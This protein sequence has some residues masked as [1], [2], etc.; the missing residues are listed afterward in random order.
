MYLKNTTQRE[1]HLRSF[2]VYAFKLPPGISV[3]WD[4]AGEQLLKIHKVESPGGKDNY[5]FSNGHG[6][7]AIFPATEKEWEKGGRQI[8][9]VERFQI[10]QNLVPRPS[11][12]KIAKQRGVDADRVTEFLADSNIDAAEIADA[13]N[14]L[15]IPDEVRNPIILKTHED[16]NTKEE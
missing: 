6:I 14:A 4:K 10:R 15:P 13:I 5:G 2:E 3:I 7:P 9:W 1:V 12:I 8:T 16:N 11:L